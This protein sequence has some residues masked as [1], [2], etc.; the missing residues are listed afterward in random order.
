M[1]AAPTNLLP[2][3]GIGSGVGPSPIMAGNVQQPG[4]PSSFKQFGSQFADATRIADSGMLKNA[5]Q[6]AAGLGILS[7][8]SGAMSPTANNGP[9]EDDEDREPY[10]PY[11]MNPRQLQRQSPESYIS[12]DSSE[13]QYF[14]NVNPGYSPVPGYAYG[15]EVDYSSM[16]PQ[17][18]NIGGYGNSYGNNGMES[19]SD[20]GGFDGVIKKLLQSGA[21]G[22]GQ[23]FAGQAGQATG[24]GGKGQI[25]APKP[26][27]MP[28]VGGQAGAP[29]QPPQGMPP[30]A[31]QMRPP[32]PTF[33]PGNSAPQQWGRPNLSPASMQ[34]QGGGGPPQGMAQG[35]MVAMAPGGFVMDA[36]ATSEFGNGSSNAGM[37]RLQQMGGVPLQGPGDGVSDSIPASIGSQ[38]A[39]VARDEVYFPPQA[40]EQMGGTQQLYDM[41]DQAHKARQNAQRGGNTQAGGR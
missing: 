14:D 40:V 38:P 36:R 37:E 30:Q 5:G 24:M 26:S 15:G 22:G 13:F 34:P 12:G 20:S 9:P 39:A 16:L 21:V 7:G 33:Q 4:F 3:A 27:Y 32:M 31:Q 6:I 2:A 41:M 28:P 23:S 11:Q 25:G 35:G 8:V 10:R 18:P 1:G 29:Q 17:R 19:L